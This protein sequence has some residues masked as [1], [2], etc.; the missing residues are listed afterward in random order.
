[1][2]RIS[3]LKL[4]SELDDLYKT[5]AESIDDI[6]QNLVNPNNGVDLNDKASL[7]ELMKVKRKE[8]NLSMEDL[9]LQTGLSY[10]TIKRIFADP[11]NAKFTNVIKILNELGIDTWAEK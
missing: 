8:A 5:F 7:S 11:S 10:S 1:M 4:R 3:V 2:S 9:E 6:E